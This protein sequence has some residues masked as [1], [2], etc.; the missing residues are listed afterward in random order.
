[1]GKSRR[2]RQKRINL[3]ALRRLH[4][5]TWNAN[6]VDRGTKCF[7]PMTNGYPGGVPAGFLGWLRGKG[8]WGDVRLHLPCGRVVDTAPGENLR[9]DIKGPPE[10]NATHVFDATVKSEYPIDWVEKFD[11]VLID[12]PYTRD[13]AESLYDTAENYAGLDRWVAN[14]KNCVKPG[15]LL[16]T[17]DYQ[18]PKRP[19]PDFN[20]IACWGIYTAMSVRHMMCFQVWQRD[21]PELV[22]GLEAWQQ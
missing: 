14:A 16:A 12:K 8:W 15:G 10:T 21:G 18:V 20:L 3:K 17:L 11:F 9:V 13:L 5:K 22:R 2:V 6:D 7:S 4:R 1:M 19:G